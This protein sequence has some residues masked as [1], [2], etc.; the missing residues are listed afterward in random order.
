MERVTVTIEDD[1][2]A[3]V[4]GIMTARGYETRSDSESRPTLIRDVEADKNDKDA[5]QVRRTPRDRPEP[6]EPFGGVPHAESRC[7]TDRHQRDR[8]PD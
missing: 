1:L 2:L 7:C 4:D 5:G 3:A 8:Q 6:R